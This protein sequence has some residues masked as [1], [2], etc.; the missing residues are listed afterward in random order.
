MHGTDD[1]VEADR[2]AGG[3]RAFVVRV[4]A[5]AHADRAGRDYPVDAP[6]VVG[7]DA[8][9]AI[10]LDNPSVSRR[11]ARLSPAA[12][13]IRVED[14]DSRDGV[15]VDGTRQR[16]AVISAGQ[17]FRIGSAILECRAAGPEPAA[18]IVVRIA[19]S[20]DPDATGREITI[21]GPSAT[22]GRAPDCD[23]VLLERDVSRRHARLDLT[24][25]GLRVTDLESSAGIAVDGRSVDTAIVEPTQEIRIGSQVC[26]ACRVEG[27]PPAPPPEI[28]EP[29]TII[30][31]D[32]TRLFAIPDL[33]AHPPADG[34]AAAPEPAAPEPAA[35]EAATPEPAPPVPA[36][37]AAEPAPAGG[38]PEVAPAPAEPGVSDQ[39]FDRT[40]V[41]PIPAELRTAARRMEDEGDPVEA[42]AHKPFL[43]DDPD[44]AWYVVDGG[45]LIFTVAVEKGEPVGGRTHFLGILA[46]QILIGFDPRGVAV[47]SGFLAVP[48]QGTVLRRMPRERLRQIA[49]DPTRA[50]DLAGLV[51][52]WVTGLSSALVANLPKKRGEEVALRAG[53]SAQLEPTQE[54]TSAQGVVWVNLWSGD[55]QFDD[56]ATPTF[57]RRDAL[58]PLTPDSWIH[59]ISDEFGPL[60]LA[61]VATRDVIADAGLWAGLQT[62][63]QVLRRCEFINKKLYAADEYLRLQQKAEHAEA[64]ERAA[65]GAI[66]QV[67]SSEGASPEQ[68][69]AQAEAEPVLLACRLVAKAIGLDVREPPLTEENL[70]FEERMAAIASSSNYRTRVVA[71]RDRWFQQDN[72]PLLGQREDGKAPVALLP[73]GP[74]S[75]VCVDPKTGT[76]T[77]VDER[78]AESLS[79]FAY[80]FYRSFTEGPQRVVDVVRFGARGLR[81]DLLWVFYMS[82]V[83]GVFGTVTPWIT[84]QV[85][86]AAIPQAQ[87]ASLVG[88][89][90][91]LFVTALATSAFKLTQ[92][93]ATVRI[94]ARMASSIQA[95]VW[96]RL[97]NLPVNFFRQFSAGDLTDRAE[98]VAAI[99]QLVSGAGVAA[100]LGSVSGLFYIVQMFSYNLRLALLAILLTAV[101]VGVNM[102]A[103][104]LQLRYQ[105]VEF[106]VRGR[107]T[108]LVLNLLT[109]VTKIRVCGAENHAFRVWA[110]QF[111]R[112]RSITFTVGTIQNVAETFAAVFPIVSSIAIFATM[113][114]LQATPGE[115]ALSTGQFIAFNAAYGLFLAA[116][117]ALGDASLSL[118]RVVPIYER[119]QPILEAAPE[120]DQSKAFPGRLTGRIELSHLFFRYNADGPWII[121]DVSLK[122]EPGEFVAFVGSSGSGKSTLMRLMLGFEQPSRGSVL[123]DNQDLNALDLRSVRQQVGVVLQ[124]SRVMP[125]EIYRNITGVTSR[126]IEDAWD[127]AEK[128]GLAEDIRQ[129]PMGMHTYVSEGGGTLSGGQRQRL[130][131]ARAIVNK[132]KILFLDEATS[133]LDN[134]TQSIVTESMDRMESTR[135]VIAHR[136]S[137]IVGADRICFL[138]NGEIAEMGTYQ[139]LMA[140]NGL[141]AQLARR[142]MA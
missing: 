59:P 19:A 20:G 82:I 75:Y 36:D 44:S 92:G 5:A 56:M 21:A 109:G 90:I 79:A 16:D 22:I 2:R 10:V 122:I 9:C 114:S 100:I 135:I 111:A 133:A 35:P 77:R 108:G 55:V 76:R 73:E 106:Q 63:Q 119:L 71:L 66:A 115:P 128:A 46:G 26:L 14:L 130:M 129:M 51:D 60:S 85:F 140:R 65:Y 78:V 126:T 86:D 37:D 118:L 38:A 7:R 98:G 62:F 97:L 34:A 1:E 87:R 6:L 24:P 39:D 61:P 139:E 17:Q 105:R 25:E 107:I 27:A 117:Q 83:I 64:A 32:R 112:Q 124:A 94:Q 50:A 141:F 41:I 95:S 88:F 52:A 113:V 125:T 58:F 74:Q 18:A 48:R 101:Y 57:A 33:A 136:L 67:L 40:V 132:P 138:H 96:D 53:E 116:M 29:E 15:W 120:V 93:I 49:Q 137:T 84:G 127:A 121:K 81:Q 80:S 11:H 69:Q 42:S 45:V 103:N 99:Q 68:F 31:R 131:I 110:E 4:V 30:D 23:V 104:Y 134:R 3:A 43:I 13:G 72:G 8:G 91:A 123:Y 54:A 70:N 47:G 12:A 28:A 89:G 142:Q 102:G